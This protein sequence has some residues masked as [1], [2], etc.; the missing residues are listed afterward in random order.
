[1]I[2]KHLVDNQSLFMEVQSI[3]NNQRSTPEEK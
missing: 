1:M 2:S 3:F